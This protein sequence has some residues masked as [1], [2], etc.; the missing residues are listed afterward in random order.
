MIE[1]EDQRER[2]QEMD[3][4]RFDGR[5]AIVTGAGRG[6][7]RAHALFFAGRGASVVV[8]DLG[9]E[10]DGTGSSTEPADSVVEEIRAA[11][12]T[13]VADHGDVA[14]SAESVVATALEHYGRLDILVNN[15]GIYVEAELADSDT[16]D[17]F[18]QV[19]T[20]LHGTQLMCKH[21]W[22]HLRESTAGRI[23]NTTSS[24][25]LG[26]AGT[27]SYSAA[28][29]GIFAFTRNLALEGA[30]HGIRANCISPG[31]YT[32]MAL[33][34][35]ALTP[36]TLEMIRVEMPAHANSGIVGYLAHE[37]CTLNG[38][39]L[40]HHGLHVSRWVLAQTDGVSVRTA[41]ELTAELIAARIDELVSA[42]H[43]HPVAQAS[44]DWSYRHGRLQAN[45]ILVT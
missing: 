29:G 23:V 30:D 8:N 13:A 31:A 10:V 34:A 16:E 12:G 33:A 27:S 9:C 28:K 15:A 6:M 24:G 7:G 19:R 2:E 4:L 18:G 22:T 11:G 44:D 20:H 45:G 1:P 17:F 41:D 43:L 25:V 40:A 38:E 42:E 39:V 37:S 3:E 26:L 21:A 5:V 32:R 14:E 35:G 36:E